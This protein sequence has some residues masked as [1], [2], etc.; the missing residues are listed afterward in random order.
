VA[1]DKFRVR[2]QDKAVFK[3]AKKWAKQQRRAQS[4]AAGKGCAVVL[5][6]AAGAVAAGIAAWKGIA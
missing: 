5:I 6:G 4:K 1:D 3:A 2:K